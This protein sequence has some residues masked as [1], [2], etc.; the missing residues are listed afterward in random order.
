MNLKKEIYKR[1][2]KQVDLVK[3]L[4]VDPSRVSMAI[5][6]IRPLPIKYQKQLCEL[7]GISLEELQSFYSSQEEENE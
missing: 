5:N 4:K 1:G 6:G 7:I 2:I 3:Q